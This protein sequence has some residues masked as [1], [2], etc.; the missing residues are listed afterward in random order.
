MKIEKRRKINRILLII[1]T[2][3]SVIALI[4]LI[5]YIISRNEEEQI[6]YEDRIIGNNYF[7]EIIIDLESKNVKRDEIETTLQEEFNIDEQTEA[8]VLSS[9]Q[10]LENFF[11]NTTFEIKF[12]NQIAYITNSYQTKKIILE[13]DQMENKFNAEEVIELQ[14]NLFILKYDT[15]M[16]TKAAYEYFK[17]VSWVKN[18]EKDEIEY[19]EVINDESQTVYGEGESDQL[20]N[21][22][23]GTNEMGLSKYKQIIRENG[24]LQ[25]VIIATIGYGLQKDHTYFSNRIDENYYNYIKQSKEIYETI[26]QGSR[27][28]E[29]IVDATSPNVRI[30][31][32]VVINDENYTS[33]SSIVQAI[34]FATKNSDVICYEFVNKENYM[35]N[36]VLENAF[37]ENVPVCCVTTINEVEETNNQKQ[38]IETD[39]L[40]SNNIEK[41]YPANNATTIAVSSLDKNAK[42]TT[43]SGSGEY[44]DFSAYST[45]VKEIFNSSSTVSKWSGSQYSNAH[46]ASAIA[47]IKTYYKEYTILE[48][49]NMLRNYCKDL[50]NEGKDTLYGYGCPNF[51][52]ITIADIDKKSPEIQEIKYDNQNWEVK[53]QIQIVA[54][55][56]IRISGWAVTDSDKKPT[57][58]NE[59]KDLISNLDVTT[60]ITENGTYYIWI[61]DSAGN[62]VNTKIQVDKVDNKAPEIEYQIDTTKL[63][64]EKYVT[65]TVTAKDELSGLNE[66]PYSWDLNTWSA[67]GNTLK[68]TENGRHII[69]VKDALGNISKEEIKIDMFPQLGEA[70]IGEGEIIKSVVVSSSWNGDT[71]NSVRITFKD[72]LKII[73]WKITESSTVP[74]SFNEVELEIEENPTINDEDSEQQNDSSDTIDN[75]TEN[76][77]NNLTVD[78]NIANSTII[79]NDINNLINNDY[80]SMNSIDN[81]INSDYSNS[82]ETR[83]LSL[84]ITVSLKT[85][86]TYYAWIKEENGNITCQTFNVSK[87]EI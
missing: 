62:A 46:I 79:D 66:L 50:G 64:T 44:I 24:N 69:Y 22:S 82:T 53:K 19:I 65:V 25:D 74:T 3:L 14:E 68:V 85:N 21:N 39:I 7:T 32:L 60:E 87:V 30:L 8:L 51:S 35:I 5:F 61:T 71:N 1:A 13:V 20:D 63:S 47:L 73:G 10:E 67:D 45:D 56:N 78:N 23:F 83:D 28:A 2:I 15:Q 43:Y 76:E 77:L 72:N 9:K 40:S 80:T 16:R 70:T 17:G 54:V 59:L 38:S 55:D 33:L 26:P 4:S 31:P 86:V 6:T 81:F 34:S 18:I 42:I 52:N 36:L 11:A 27:V 41:I 37:R 49:Y 58:W 75:I 84:T 29:V 48:V 12:E 57:K